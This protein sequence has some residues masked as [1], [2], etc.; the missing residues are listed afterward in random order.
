MIIH[1]V[2]CLFRKILQRTAFLVA[3]ITKDEVTAVGPHFPHLTNK[4]YFLFAAKAILLEKH[5]KT[6]KLPENQEG[7]YKVKK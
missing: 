6:A 3:G 2:G 7:K 1:A 5:R 4:L